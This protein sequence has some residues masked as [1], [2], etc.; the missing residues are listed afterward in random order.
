M[1]KSFFFSFDGPGLG[2]AEG[3]VPGPALK[4]WP[5]RALF[6]AKISTMIFGEHRLT[7][8]CTIDARC[9]RKSST[10]SYTLKLSGSV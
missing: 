4:K 9:L 2:R 7:F 8:D 5:G 10:K 3:K 6:S 1:R